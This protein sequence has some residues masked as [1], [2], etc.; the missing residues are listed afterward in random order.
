MYFCTG[1]LA[2]IA[3]I[4]GTNERFK[5]SNVH[6]LGSPTF[7]YEYTFCVMLTEGTISCYGINVLLLGKR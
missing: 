3:Q 5:V 2:T 7:I 6:A 4:A 1:G